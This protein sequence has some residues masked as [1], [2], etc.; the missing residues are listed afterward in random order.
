MGYLAKVLTAALVMGVT[1][2]GPAAADPS[3]GSAADINTLAG[4]LS[5][6][7]GLNNCT[8]QPVP[9]GA[10]AYLQCGQSPDPSGP[11]LAK[12]FLFGDDDLAS[13][14]N[15]LIGGDALSNCADKPSP[16]RGIRAA[17][18]PA[19]GMSRVEPSRTMP[20]SSGPTPPRTYWA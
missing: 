6:G 20:R 3:T 9:R 14:F 19:R 13:S 11:I 8:A 4:A 16:R 10:L 5:K 1:A 12:Y 15:A 2:A 17:R 7:Y 18:P